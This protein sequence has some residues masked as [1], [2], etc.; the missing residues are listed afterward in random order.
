MKKKILIILIMLLL[1]IIG[2]VIAS[3]FLLNKNEKE[4][5]SV[6]KDLDYSL[7]NPPDFED[8]IIKIRP[9]EPI[10]LKEYIHNISEA[11]KIQNEN[12]SF[13]FLFK[14]FLDE[15]YETILVVTNGELIGM[16]INAEILE[17]ADV[18]ENAESEENF[19]DTFSN[20]LQKT[21][22]TKMNESITEKWNSA[23]V[24]ENVNFTKVLNKI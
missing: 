17:K 9:T 11:R 6:L 14:V 21:F 19:G 23:I 24:V 22:I 12:G 2:I 7:K 15:N 5:L 13:T 10:S 3:K 1:V 20:M 8:N 18:N 16:T 4:I